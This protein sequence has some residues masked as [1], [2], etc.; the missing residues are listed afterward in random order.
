[1]ARPHEAPARSTEIVLLPL[2]KRGIKV[3]TL[4]VLHFVSWIMVT[5]GFS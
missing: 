3:S 4:Q 2:H 5:E 1:M